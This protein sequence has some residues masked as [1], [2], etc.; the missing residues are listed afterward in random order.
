M[1]ISAR[2]T[3]KPGFRSSH[4][5][6]PPCARL[7]NVPGCGS[8]NTVH[9]VQRLLSAKSALFNF[10]LLLCLFMSLCMCA[11][12]EKKKEGAT[13]VNVFLAARS[14]WF[15]AKGG[16]RNPLIRL[17]PGLS[18]PFC[19]SKSLLIICCIIIPTRCVC[20]FVCARAPSHVRQ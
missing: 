16:R 6:Y 7:I 11:G 5:L 1:T 19:Y 4:C 3:N 13:R 14:Y 20:A 18:R 10:Y 9:R 8:G 2:K 17:K 15:S 12:P